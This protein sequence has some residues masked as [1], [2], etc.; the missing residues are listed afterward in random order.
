VSAGTPP[1]LTPA[2]AKSAP[3]T[4]A[5]GTTGLTFNGFEVISVEEKGGKYEVVLKDNK[6]KITYKDWPSDKKLTDEKGKSIKIDEYLKSKK[7]QTPPEKTS[8]ETYDNFFGKSDISPDTYGGHVWGNLAEGLQWAS[9]V[10]TLT[11]LVGSFMPKEEGEKVKNVGLAISGGLT[12]GKLVYGLFNNRRGSGVG[13]GTGTGEVGTGGTLAGIATFA[14]VTY[15]ILAETYKEE[16]TK[17]KFVE[18]KCMEWQ[19][20]LG[21]DNCE[22]CNANPLTPCSEYRCKSLGQ[23]CK[24]VNKGTLF[25]R[26]INS[27]RGDSSSPGIRPAQILKEGYVYADVKERPAGNAEAGVSGMKIK[28]KNGCLPAFTP[29]KFGIETFGAN[30]KP[31]PAQCK[32]DFNHTKSFNEMNYYMNGN[33]LY[34]EN[35]TEII[36]LPGTDNINLTMPGVKNDGEYKF[37]VRCRDG[38]GNENRDEF[39]ISFCTEKGPDVL[40]PIIKSTS[41]TSGGA[42]QYK[43]DNVSLEVYVNEPTECKWSRKDAS[44]SN[45]ENNI[46]CSNKLWEMNAELLYTCKT[47]LTSIKDNAENKF[48]I[49]CQDLSKQNNTMQ[50]SYELILYGTQPLSILK[51]SPNRTVSGST[52]S[53]QVELE[54]QTDNG[55][56]RGES[57]CY[58]SQTG[59]AGDFIEMKETGGNFHKQTLDLTG[60]TYTY[61]YKCIDAGGNTAESSTTFEVYVD[62]YS[63]VILRAYSLDNKLVIITDEESNCYYSTETCN[64][65]ITK[66]EGIS[67]P[68]DNSKSH[69]TEFKTLQ[70][71]YIKCK[72]E[73][74]NSA[75]PTECSAIIKPYQAIK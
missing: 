35:H 67:L 3:T 44:Y 36:S 62:T 49:R 54:V 73:K 68:Y 60:G 18:F 7:S 55:F 22:K 14:I 71:Y 61:Y 26:C 64:F 63:P 40:A 21:G 6:G 69:Y 15:L 16:K 53:V 10:L 20:P 58:Y 59:K 23:T 45:M 42:V 74:G 13:G 31:E 43:A 37:Y 19:A 30:G 4:P 75:L 50:Q 65:D 8:Q 48:Y 33:S 51:T 39:I 25:E 12:A 2:P 52:S 70:T 56:R 57:T 41:I 1:P 11:Q 38:N 32:I 17:E 28:Y 5:K 24:I 72:D 9:A 47:K 66:S 29:L 27:G 46:E 34:T